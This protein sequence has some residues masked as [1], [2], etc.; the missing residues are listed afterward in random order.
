MESPVSLTPSQRRVV[1]E[2]MMGGGGRAARP[3]FPDDLAR[4][5]RAELQDATADAAERLAMLGAEVHVNKA[6]LARVH[7]CE[8]L[9]QAESA[10]GFPGWS[11]DLARGVVAHKAIELG[12]FMAGEPAP[13]EL[14]DAAIDRIIEEG[15]DRTPRTWLLEAPA[16]ELAE[17]R[18]AANDLV[19]KFEASFPPLKKDWRP[20]LESPVRVELHAGQIVLRS[21]VDLALGKPE[22]TQAG[23]LVVDFK[24][25]RAYPH[26]I[27][28]LRYYALLETFRS[29]VPP[30]R[31]AS[32]YLDAG[33]WHHE[34]VTEELLAI[35][36]RRVIDG[37]LKLAAL[38]TNERE[39]TFTPGPACGYCRLRDTCEGAAVWAAQREE[40]GELS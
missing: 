36:M 5:L 17:L 18:A 38:R 34:D 13:L 1:D 12:V 40:M 8:R 37:V 31:V 2:L 25:G 30:F 10:V 19:C 26:H 20:R 11:K 3:H 32:Y 9:H 24:S 23:V 4:R 22:G 21:K 39:P 28:D 7:Q 29:G 27:D 15:D 16:T 14:V 33:N 6:E 35:T